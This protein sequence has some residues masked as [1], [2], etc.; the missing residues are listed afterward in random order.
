M[1]VSSSIDDERVLHLSHG[2]GQRA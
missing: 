2:N 1:D